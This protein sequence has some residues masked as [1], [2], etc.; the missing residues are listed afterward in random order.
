MDRFVGGVKI[1]GDRKYGIEAILVGVALV[2][3]GIEF[4]VYLPLQTRPIDIVNPVTNNF[5][6]VRGNRKYTTQ[7][8]FKS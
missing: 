1:T 3:V 5:L 7:V 8:Q 2:V 4:M 6:F